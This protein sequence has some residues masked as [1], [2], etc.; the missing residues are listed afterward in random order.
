M[1]ELLGR[2]VVGFF[3]CLVLWVVFVGLFG[4]LSD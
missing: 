2:L 1:V 4:V 3:S